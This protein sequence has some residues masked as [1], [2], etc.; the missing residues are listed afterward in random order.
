M[1]T[2]IPPTRVRFA[3]LTITTVVALLMYLDRACIGW[4]IH[5]DSFLKSMPLES[6]QMD[7]V[8]SAFFWAY[9]LAQMPA[10]WLSDR[11]GARWLMAIYIALWSLFTVGTSFATNFTLL[12][13]ARLGCGLA[14]AGAFPASSSIM[15]KW[16][17]IDWRGLSSSM[18]TM[19][20]RIG[21][22]AAPV[23]TAYVILQ[24]G[25]WR[26]AGWI[27]GV[28]GL[29]VALA[30]WLIF[31]EHPRQHPHCNEAEVALLAER[32]GDFLPVTE[33]PRAFPWKPVCRSRNLWLLNIY[34]FL[35]NLGWV[36]L[37]TSLPKY[38]KEVCHFDDATN[39]K[40]STVAL[41]IGIA[42][43]PLGG[44]FTD[45]CTRRLG[46]VWGRRL[47]LCLTRFGAAAAYIAAM[48]LHSPVGLAL[49]FGAVAF[50]TDFALPATWTTMQDISGRHQAQIFGWSN[51]W[52]NFGAAVQPLLMAW[53]LLRFDTQHNYHAGMIFS[54]MVMFLCGVIALGINPQQKVIADEA[55]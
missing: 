44:I 45:L 14:E 28:V 23:L 37:L 20:G 47:P 29:G 55:V 17:H 4:I 53:V 41:T 43:L 9:A 3:V 52:G 48:Y 1:P 46:P 18:V 2:P 36:F 30:F 27:Y 6:W 50:C 8:V 32:R 22:A 54:A 38:L 26:W 35:A 11:F 34:Q 49:A 15:T 10:G 5:S 7:R 16:A 51:M 33:P 24:A 31:R 12:M 25:D 21:G 42:A 19:G 13:L 40:V 39:G